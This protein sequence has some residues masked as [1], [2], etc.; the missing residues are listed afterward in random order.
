M[1]RAIFHID[2]AEKWRLVIGNAKNLVASAK[3]EAW[4]IEI[5][6][7]SAAVGEFR[8]GSS[9]FA[10]ELASLARAGVAIRACANALRGLD[11]PEGDVPDFAKVVP[12]GVRELVDRQGEGFAYIKP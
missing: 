2:E 12:V 1:V 11:I 7:N 6:A 5:L 8:K 9:A 10:N 3:G 4:E